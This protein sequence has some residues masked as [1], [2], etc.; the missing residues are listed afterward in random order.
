M[1][2]GYTIIYVPDVRATL[3]FYGRAFG[4]DARFITDEGD[5]AE[6]VTGETTLAFAS[7]ALRDANGVAARE[8]RRG[9]LAPGFEIALVTDDVPAAMERAARAGAEVVVEAT[10]K[11]W[12]Q[13][14]GYVRD[15]DGILVEVCTPVGG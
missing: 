6:L 8:N 11:P 15:L 5:Y 4:I 10:Q 14:V 12:G 9:A 1:K 13:V 7:E 2:F 3:A